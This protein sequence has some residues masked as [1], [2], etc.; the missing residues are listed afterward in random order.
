MLPH[1]IKINCYIQYFTCKS[2]TCDHFEHD[3]SKQYQSRGQQI[4]TSKKRRILRIHTYQLGL[5]QPTAAHALSVG[6]I[7]IILCPLAYLVRQY[8]QKCHRTAEIN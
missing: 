7:P 4:Q 8:T 6:Y 5:L 3:L 1:V 2:Q